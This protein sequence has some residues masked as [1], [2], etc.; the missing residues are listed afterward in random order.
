MAYNAA[1]ALERIEHELIDSMMRNLRRHLKEESDMGFDW[2]Q[3]QVLQLKYLEAYRKKNQ[4][5]YGPQFSNINRRIR[6]AIEHARVNGQ[7]EEEVRILKT[8]AEHPE[9]QKKIKPSG[10]ADIQGGSFFKINEQKLDALIKATDSDMTRGEHAVLRR[11]D[12]QYR[13]IIFDAQMYANTGAG[14]VE[15]A[16]D[17][18]THDFI[19][20]GI[21]SIVYK[22]GARHTISDYADMAIRT[23]ERRATL[24]GAGETRKEWG[25]S[26]VIVN[27]RGTMTGGNFGHACPQCIPWLGKILIDD[28]Y[29]GGRPD[30][31]HQL[32]STAMQQGFLHPRCKDSFHT[33]YPGITSVPDPVTKKELADGAAADRQEAE[34]QYAERQAEKYECLAETRLDPENRQKEKARA[35]EWRSRLP[36]Q[37]EIQRRKEE[38]K[39]R[40]AETNEQN[41]PSAEAHEYSSAEGFFIDPKMK[42]GV[43]EGFEDAAQRVYERYGRK[44]NIKGIAPVKTSNS[45]RHQASYNP[46]TGILSL[47]NSSMEQYRKNAEKFFA[48]GWNAS[49]DPYG[50]FYHEIGH[51]IWTDLSPEAR[52]QIKEIYEEERH[53]AYLKWME[54]GG[55]RSG[56]GQAEVFQKAL[57]RYAAEN[58]EE[59]FSEA[60]SQIM[61]GRMRPAS[62][63]VS[64]VIDSQYKVK[65]KAEQLSLKKEI[66]NAKINTK[67]AVSTKITQ[68]GE[69]L[70]PMSEIE[71][72]R[73]RKALEAHGIE[74]FAA[75][76]GDD[77]RYMMFLGA[78]G[79]YSNGRI[80]HVGKIPSRGTFFE[81]IIHMAQ[82]R[83]YGELLST[84]QLEL[85]AR[86]IEANRKLLK[87]KKAYRLDALDVADIERNLNDWE[88]RFMNITGVDYDE[89]NYRKNV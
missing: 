77:L 35:E 23:A 51:A 30:G 64:S 58:E 4:K 43:V 84:D 75:F 15:K 40:H 2:E 25:L 48:D 20:R 1:A 88:Q 12:D 73:I 78:E 59:F 3:W 38:W 14:T 42:K 13:K 87:H 81:E 83:K 18:A 76:E 16:I 89:S 36:S 21:D 66:E 71:Y 37:D 8:L 65:T 34:R 11:C 5:K 53:K 56:L 55:S 47:K 41:K 45:K 80:T 29:S 79:T 19:A 9:L 62:R 39:R 86:E 82:S 85:C 69:V 70:N 27:R 33:Y 28:V 50:T 10:N 46:T 57:S 54:M 68:G 67:K 72:N 6:H 74:V 52:K 17:M 22:N 7:K 63:R 60:F 49:G 24:M 44:L 61:S 26:L 31:K 32:V